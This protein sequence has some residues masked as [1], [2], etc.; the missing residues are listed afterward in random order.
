MKITE[1]GKIKIQGFGQGV[2]FPRLPPG[3]PIVIK[4]VYYSMSLR[5]FSLGIDLGDRDNICW[6]LSLGALDVCGWH[7]ALFS[8]ERKDRRWGFD[9]LFLKELV[10]RSRRGWRFWR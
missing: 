9:F 6:E 10:Q 4:R 1:Q 7:G 2:P 5:P 8:V 3:K